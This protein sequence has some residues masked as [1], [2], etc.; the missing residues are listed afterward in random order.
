MRSKGKHITHL[1][2]KHKTDFIFLQETKIRTDLLASQITTALG[3]QYS[4]FSLGKQN[5]G[6][7]VTIL[8]TSHRWKVTIKDRDNEG[9]IAIVEIENSS[10][11][12]TLVNI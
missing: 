4:C 2:H 8:Q 11:T 6:S 12:Y 3:L 9:R 5:I 7:G 10:H 1:I